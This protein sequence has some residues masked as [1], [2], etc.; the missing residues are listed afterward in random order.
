M[1]L[2]NYHVKP[3]TSVRVN[4][5][6]FLSSS[7]LI[8][9]LGIVTV[10]YPVASQ[11]WLTRAQTWVTA[12]FG[13]YY[14]LLMVLSMGFVFWLA[15]SRHGTQLL[16]H[17]NEAP[18]FS[19]LSWIAMLF[20]AGIG[21][22]LVYYGAYEPLAHFLQPPEGQGGTV[23]AAREAMAITFL[24]WGL[25]GWALYAL[26]ATALAWF[27]YRR[28]QPLA[29]RSALYGLFRHK[30]HGW[31]G[32][33][34]DTCGILVT[35]VSMVTNLGIGALLVKA[36]LNYLFDLPQTPQ[37]LFTLIIIMM[38]VATVATVI[39]IE[40]GIAFLSN[41]NVGFLCLLLL[42]LFITGPTLTMLNGLLQNTGDYLSS[43]VAKS[44]EVY[45]Y[46]KAEKWQGAWTL[47]YWAWWVAWAPF[48]GLFIAR[49]SRGRTIR[50]LILGVMLIPLGFTLAW[51]SLFG[52]T[53]I[54]LVFDQGHAILGQIALS[55]PPMAVYKLLEY[56]P[57]PTLTAVFTVIISFVLF[58]TPVDSGT[59]MI[60]NLASKGGTSEDDAP[61]WLRLFWAIVTT[62]LCAGLL[63]AGSFSAMQTAVVV[64]GLPFSVVILL[65]MVSLYRDLHRA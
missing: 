29:L 18:E 46:S 25:H 4:L 9:L 37:L 56:F 13:W 12:V 7:L 40:K 30:I 2:L 61:V 24:H 17:E 1:A 27:A 45:L 58:L 20:S 19:Y 26:I 21:I 62:V 35:V 34:V 54:S 33:T 47:F 39:G 48:V 60:A 16:G 10:L 44:F 11:L 64:A 5:P 3:T 14:M 52:N 59:L 55:D 41:L 28:D 50:Q 63:Y 23:H 15:C 49:I 43:V 8:L 31:I 32:H 6:V 38:V 65:Y 22:A 36:G 53:A 42:F 57:W 51:L